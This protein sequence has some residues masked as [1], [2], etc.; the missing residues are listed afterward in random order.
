MLTIIIG[1]VIILGLVWLEVYKIYDFLLET[2]AHIAIAVTLLVAIFIGCVCPINGYMEPE[3]IE[4][5]ELATFSNN[6]GSIESD[7]LLYV[8]VSDNNVV[9]SYRYEVPNTSTVEGKTYKVATA[10][11]NVTELE[12]NTDKP[13]LQIYETKAKKSIWG[14]A[15]GTKKTSYVFIVPEGSISYSVALN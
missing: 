4:E 2:L 5:I 3:L 12:N 13:V 10:S 6:T 15:I 8:E 14:L 9:Y 11:E 7:S 1:V